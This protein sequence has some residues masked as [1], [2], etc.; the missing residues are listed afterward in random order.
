M[1]KASV[2]PG[3][4]ILMDGSPYRIRRLIDEQLWQIESEE[5][6]QYRQIRIKEI[7]RKLIEGCLEFVF[8]Q[9]TA[10]SKDVAD[11]H[12]HRAFDRLPEEMQARARARFAYVTEIDQQGL[13]YLSERHLRPII[14]S[15]YKRLGDGVR[16]PSWTT[17]YRWYQKFRKGGRDIRVL[18]D[19]NTKRGNRKQRFDDQLKAAIDTAISDV[20]LTKERPSMKDTY[21]HARG[22]VAKRNRDLPKTCRIPLPSYA[23]VRR[24]ILAIPQYDRDL[25]RFGAEFVRKEYRAAGRGPVADAPLERVEID[26]TVLDV[27]L[28]DD[29][30]L[31]P[32]GRPTLT[33]CID[34]YSKCILGMSISWEPP[35]YATVAECLKHAILPKVDVQKQFGTA[36]GWDCHGVMETLVLDNALEFHGKSIEAAANSLGINLHFCQVRSP[37]QKGGIERAIGTV[38]RTLLHRLPGTTFSNIFEKMD[39]RPENHAVLTLDELK[40]LMTRWIVDVYH[41]T[42]HRTTKETPAERWAR[43]MED[44]MPQLPVSRSSLDFMTGHVAQRALTHKGIEFSNLRYNSEKLRALRQAYGSRM[45]VEIRYNTDNMGSIYEPPRVSRRLFSLSQAAS[46]DSSCWR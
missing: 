29:K 46:A 6:G 30:T 7:H 5:T 44:Q 9:T 31:L 3:Q 35:G 1:P 24:A 40:R 21:D 28:L 37:W 39:Y 2:N 19:Q 36:K 22:L 43:S 42:P 12:L 33:M 10:A 38:N 23:Q 8:D 18:V 25:A 14:D 34:T 4:R 15:V 32:V 45:K 26:H 20:Y 13:E 11:A 17:V 16:K 27:M 41:Q